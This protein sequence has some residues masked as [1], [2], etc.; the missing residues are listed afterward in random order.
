VFLSNHTLTGI[1]LALA[2]KNP[3]VIAPVAFASH[4]ALD[5]LPHF[6]HPD[7]D[8]DSFNFKVIASV[9]SALSSGILIGAII[10]WPQQWPALVV[11]A[12]FA[13]LPDLLYIPQY[14]FHVT[15]FKRLFAVHSA[16]QWSQT[17]PGI[18]SEG[19]WAAAMI[20]LLNRK[21]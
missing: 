5:S 7:L 9:D 15:L 21:W 14:F 8:F 16:V 1:V 3:L 19:V 2:I 12:F 11:G 20:Y 17:P 6:G 18:I 4:L 13:T 10:L